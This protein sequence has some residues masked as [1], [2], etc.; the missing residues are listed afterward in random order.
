MNHRQAYVRFMLL[1]GSAERVNIAFPLLCV[2]THWYRWP[3]LLSFK[4]FGKRRWEHLEYFMDQ[5]HARSGTK[6][7]GGNWPFVGLALKQNFALVKVYFCY[8]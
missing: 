8:N 6:K 2:C 7:N 4:D 5:E 3:V 1:W